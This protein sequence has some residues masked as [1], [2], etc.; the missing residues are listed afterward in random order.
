VPVLVLDSPSGKIAISPALFRQLCFRGK[1]ETTYDSVR[2]SSF[3]SLSII[4][5]WNVE[6]L[7]DNPYQE[8]TN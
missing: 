8:G 5:S 2:Y 1:P 3:F 4:A 6:L 7:V